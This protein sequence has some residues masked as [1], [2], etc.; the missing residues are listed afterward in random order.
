MK[1]AIITHCHSESTLPLAKYIAK[2][3]VIVDY[4]MFTFTGESTV[5]A[6]DFGTSK[7]IIGIKLLKK[8][9]LRS[10]Y[11]YMDSENVN[12]YLMILPRPFSVIKNRLFRKI[13]NK[14]TEKFISY[15][16]NKI[17]EK[18]YDCINIIG[19]ADF[20]IDLHKQII[21]PKITHSLHEVVSHFKADFNEPTKL[22]NYLGDSK[23]PIIV[24]SKK[25]KSDLLGYNIIDEKNIHLIPFGLFET[26]T[27][28][29]F[30][31][32]SLSELTSD[33][34][35][36][37]GYF[38]PYKGLSFLYEAVLLARKTIPDLKIVVAG[39]GTDPI[40]DKMLLDT[41]FIVI[42]RFLL[43]EEIVIL[44]KNARAIICPYLSASQSG[45]VQTT[46]LFDKP[47]I[48]TKVGAFVEVLTN[49]LDS[50]LVSPEDVIELSEAIIRI[51]NPSVYSDLV[52]GVK[53]FCLNKP[54]FDWFSISNKYFDLFFKD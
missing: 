29:V 20:L 33:Y 47:I 43:N 41:S 6:F 10:M 31:N 49:G 4:Y 53:G 54:D 2:K 22:L 1:L 35:L 16:C 45:I 12:I 19:Q 36:F 27:T 38:N 44:N 15:F 42:N 7:N 37:Y 40:I 17:S 5:S 11:H 32:E 51:Y 21:C 18:K 23:V 48:A 52:D 25:T 9:R 30:K 39:S 28:C 34:L 13:V 50:L 14:I 46:F 24:H 8:N 26:Y 3:D